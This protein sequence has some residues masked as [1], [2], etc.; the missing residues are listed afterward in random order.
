MH[1]LADCVHLG[2]VASTKVTDLTGK[3]NS[4]MTPTRSTPEHGTTASDSPTSN[5]CAATEQAVCCEP[6][7]K[8]ECC[9]ANQESTSCGCQ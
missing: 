8:T 1:R 4:S 7:A 2:V 6:D 5:C 9:G 3:R